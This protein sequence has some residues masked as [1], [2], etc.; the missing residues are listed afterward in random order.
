MFEVVD[1]IWQPNILKNSTIWWVRMKN[2]SI[3]IFEFPK[4]NMGPNF[5]NSPKFGKL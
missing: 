3:E 1:P 4:T 2:G 5:K